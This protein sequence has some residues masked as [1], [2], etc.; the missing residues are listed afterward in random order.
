MLKLIFSDAIFADVLA[1]S[2]LMD[3]FEAAAGAEEGGRET[4]GGRYIETVHAFE[5]RR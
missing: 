4:S 2:Q 1:D 3:A 5:I